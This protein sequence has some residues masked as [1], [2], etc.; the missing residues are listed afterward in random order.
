MGEAFNTYTDS[1][2]G[3]GPTD[4]PSFKPTV[5]KSIHKNAAGFL[6]ATTIPDVDPTAFR[7]IGFLQGM[8]HQKDYEREVLTAPDVPESL[9]KKIQD[10]TRIVQKARQANRDGYWGYRNE[11]L[12]QH[13]VLAA[14]INLEHRGRS[15][16]TLIKSMKDK[17]RLPGM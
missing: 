16:P 14:E 8:Q 6:K 2:R 4:K 5:D 9:R 10:A 1:L 15:L 11:L 7:G 3:K 12:K 17:G 13:A